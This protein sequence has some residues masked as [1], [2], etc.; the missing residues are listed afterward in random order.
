VGIIW[1][2]WWGNSKI[3]GIYQA[4]KQITGH[5]IWVGHVGDARDVPQL[6]KVGIVAV[7]DLAANELPL[8]FNRD[9]VYCRFPLV[10]G[11]GNLPWIVQ[12]AVRTVAQFLTDKVPVFVYCGAG[13]S[14]TLC[15]T[16]AAIALVENR[17]LAD[18]L[19]FVT[20]SGASDVSTSLFAEI[21]SL[22]NQ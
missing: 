12:G 5:R 20:Q 1:G 2:I 6:L 13:M 9:M 10:D 15:V 16:A 14:R 11:A 19:A 8:V 17:S 7:V 21:Q 4:M 22:V 18:S 3:V